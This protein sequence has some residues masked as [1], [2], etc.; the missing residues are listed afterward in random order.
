VQDFRSVI[1]HST[2]S[3]GRA[4]VRYNGRTTVHVRYASLGPTMHCTM[5]FAIVRVGWRTLA[6]RVNV[7][8]R[9]YIFPLDSD[10]HV[11]NVECRL[12]R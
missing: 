12:I 4:V 11:E 6:A 8:L 7:L 9:T 2:L 10:P 1:V 5:Y 3:Y